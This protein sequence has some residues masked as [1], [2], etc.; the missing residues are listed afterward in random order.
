M[1]LNELDKNE[2]FCRPYRNNIKL[3]RLFPVPHDSPK[4]FVEYR[5]KFD[6]VTADY[7]ELVVIPWTTTELAIE[8][9]ENV[10][11]ILDDP[12]LE[13]YFLNN[14]KPPV[15]NT[16]LD[17]VECQKEDEEEYI[18]SNFEEAVDYLVS[19]HVPCDDPRWHFSGGMALRNDWGLWGNKTPIAK[20]FTKHELYHGDDRSGLLSDAVQAKLNG[21]EFDVMAQIKYYHE[22][23]PKQYG[24]RC[25]LE[26]M[27]K[28]FFEYNKSDI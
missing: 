1:Y 2:V 28:D 24:E 23:W 13:K 21:E 9:L 10:W 12:K 14:E 4:A 15:L 17:V 5:V 22:W 11:D 19:L 3:A 6:E 16:D 20:W 18:P 27:R 8:D 25:S 26:Q 7:K